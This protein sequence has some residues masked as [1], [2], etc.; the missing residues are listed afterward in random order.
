MKMASIVIDQKILNNYSKPSL[1]QTKR[2]LV[3]ARAKC[4]S[5]SIPAS[6]IYR[7]Y[8]QNL[9]NNLLKVENDI[10]ASRKKIDETIYMYNNIEAKTSDK[11]KNLIATSS[12][13]PYGFTNSKVVKD[14]SNFF[15]NAI[16]E[17]GKT[18]SEIGST[19]SGWAK[20]AWNWVSGTAAPAV[21]GVLK[22]TGSL[23][24]VTVQ[25][26]LSGVLQVVEAVGDLALMALG[27]VA[28]IFTGL[29]DA[30]QA[31]HGAITGKEWHS[32][33]KSM[34]QNDSW[35]GIKGVVSYQW[36][37]KLNDKVNNSAY[38]KWLNENSFGDW[39]RTDGTLAKVAQGIGYAVGVTA[40][41]VATFGTATPLV[42]GAT[43]GSL[44]LSKYTS[45][46]WNNNKVAIDTGDDNYDI[47]LNYDELSTL[48]NDGKLIK[49]IQES[50][51]DGNLQ[52]TQFIFEK[53]K[54]G[55][56]NVTVNGQ[57]FNC[58]VNETGILK[59]L[60]YGGINGVWEGCQWFVGAKIG[61]ASFSKIFGGTGKDLLNS[62]IRV[63]LDSA[64]GAAEIPFRTALDCMFNDMSWEEAWNKNG[65]WN[66]VLS[67]TLIAGLMSTGGEAL[68]VNK[69]LNNKNSN[70][71]SSMVS[72]KF[73]KSKI[74]LD[75]VS[76][77]SYMQNIAKE[78][79]ET[80]VEFEKLKKIAETDE[81][82]DAIYAMDH[83]YAG[84]ILE[85]K[86]YDNVKNRLESLNDKLGSLKALMDDSGQKLT[87]IN[88]QDSNNI[89][90]K[91]FD[92][93]AD[94]ADYFEDPKLKLVEKA[95]SL[96]VDPNLDADISKKINN[97][98]G[99]SAADLDT[100]EMFNVLYPFFSASESSS[101]LSAIN[102]FENTSL[103]KWISSLSDSEKDA[104]Y[105]YT[106]KGGFEIN[107]CL[108]KADY[109]V[110]SKTNQK[111][112]GQG[113]PNGEFIKWPDDN[114]LEKL[115]GLIYSSN[116]KNINIHSNN[117]VN[118]LDNAIGKFKLEEPITV[119]RG[120]DGFGDNIDMDLLTIGQQITTS[121][122]SS[123]SML[124]DAA[125]LTKNKN[126]LLEINIPDGYNGAYIE[127]ISGIK[128]YGQ[129]EFL[130]K[131]NSTIEI[132]DIS[133]GPNGKKIIKCDLIPNNVNDNFSIKNIDDKT[134]LS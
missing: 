72:N 90:Y 128:N 51:E 65:G 46:A 25:S 56:Y 3:Q 107:A 34:W 10:T 69:I 131:R 27:G 71:L 114:A 50:G 84:K 55:S 30:G 62:G 85:F 60:A 121:G 53:N 5:L 40:L 109:I 28:S 79:N 44:G 54:D 31:I 118:E 18:A 2:Y 80:L 112:Y 119:Y 7:K 23:I 14:V 11:V 38:G 75:D 32:V 37:N 33:T 47:S 68:S 29:Y 66:G 115:T 100:N 133:I 98:L 77:S 124:S 78:Y 89:S 22:K 35:G 110:D 4:N 19:V 86:K 122:Y 58:N 74:Q 63:G 26:V 126:Y 9:A 67:Q 96:I 48:K 120:I 87:G 123:C 93:K 21:W 82:K 6:F 103:G 130:L 81:Y 42:L 49:E 39:A 91:K 83:N 104:I 108:N 94:I 117:I 36:A 92:S 101:I 8:L 111:I 70:N 13:L 134:R 129:L 97:F 24:A 125:S 116:G 64:T 127:S 73:K 52:T 57:K 41:S 102:N 20:N 113:L 132:T 105:S 76:D 99:Q 106:K 88:L 12:V 95:K 43:A 16:D 45:E 17:L 61:G 1:D 15:D 59:G